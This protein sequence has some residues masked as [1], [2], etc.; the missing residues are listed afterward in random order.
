MPCIDKIYS[1][2]VL[3]G[4]DQCNGNCSFCSGR[5][6]RDQAQADGDVPRNLEAAL[7]LS[8]KYG[9]WSVSITSSGE[10]TLSPNSITNVLKTMRDLRSEGVSFPFVNLFTNGITIADDDFIHKWS[11]HYKDVGIFT[12]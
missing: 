9:G 10:P 6:L 8:S 3:V 2:S 7:R 12:I 11:L 4:S 1:V 5:Y